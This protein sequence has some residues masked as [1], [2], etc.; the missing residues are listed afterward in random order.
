MQT[1]IG[2]EPEARSDGARLTMQIP[3]VARASRHFFVV[4][5]TLQNV[6]WREPK[7]IVGVPIA[8]SQFAGELDQKFG[9]G[10]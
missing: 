5:V 1:G 10:Q 3:A 6:L 8:P 2:A 9:V 4:G 7:C